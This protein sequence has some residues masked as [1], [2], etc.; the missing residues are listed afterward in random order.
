MFS[1]SAYA[2]CP[3]GQPSKVIGKITIDQSPFMG[4]RKMRMVPTALWNGLNKAFASLVYKDICIET[5]PFR[6]KSNSGERKP[7]KPV[8][9]KNLTIPSLVTE[10]YDHF[11]EE[12]QD[13]L[14]EQLNEQEGDMSMLVFWEVLEQEDVEESF[15]DG[16]IELVYTVYDL[17][18]EIQTP[19]VLELELPLKSKRVAL[20]IVSSHIFEQIRGIK[21]NIGDLQSE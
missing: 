1:S 6:Y 16:I 2:K 5:K 11:E 17:D 19:Y 21:E 4:G 9:K 18:N 15:R 13:F 7:L 20:E 8:K 3:P 12:D 10:F 14:A